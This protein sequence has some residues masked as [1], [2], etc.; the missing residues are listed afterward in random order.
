MSDE[1]MEQTTHNQSPQHEEAMEEDSV[2]SNEGDA[3]EE[4]HDDED[5]TEETNTSE[6]SRSTKRKK[7]SKKGRLKKRRESAIEPNASSTE[8]CAMLGL[9][10]VPNNFTEEDINSITSAKA[11]ALR[12]RPQLQ[13]AN[14]K[15]LFTKLQ[16]LVQAKYREFQACF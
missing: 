5:I 9:T 10:D 3:V 14:P 1:E 13:A 7:G 15:A 12:V 16:Q 4:D 2:Q 11:F 8:I 6:H